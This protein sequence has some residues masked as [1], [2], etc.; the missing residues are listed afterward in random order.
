MPR[1]ICPNPRVPGSA[2]LVL[3]GAFMGNGFQILLTPGEGGG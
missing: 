2:S 3:M 1:G